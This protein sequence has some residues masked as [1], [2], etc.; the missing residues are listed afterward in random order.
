MSKRPGD[1]HAK[2]SP[3]LTHVDQ[4][5]AYRDTP[6]VVYRYFNSY[7][8]RAL[9]NRLQEEA[10]DQ[11]SVMLVPD[12]Y[13]EA[14]L[15]VSMTA[16][17]TGSKD[18][19]LAHA[20][21]MVELA[22]LDSRARLHMT[23]CLE[24]LERDDEAIEQLCELLMR[25]HDPQSLGVAYYRMAFFQW[26]QGNLT[27]AQACY[28]YAMRFLPQAVPMLAMELSVLYLQN[29]DALAQEE[30]SDE[31]LEEAL[32]AQGIPLA[33][34]EQTT[35]LFYDCARASLDAEI[36]PVAR[37]FAQIMSAFGSDDV[38]TGVIRSLEDEPD[39]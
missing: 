6:H 19:A 11:R 34:T 4:G 22:P 8:E 3:V 18:E 9:F 10:G 7:V 27:A 20:Q 2:V 12:A 33:P 1:A 26:K 15:L 35:E 39:R 13:Y 25:A 28:Q 30:S 36:F 17:M 38:I 21:R 31:Q 24:V 16:L 32:E 14:H 37:T 23:K 29:P 5:E